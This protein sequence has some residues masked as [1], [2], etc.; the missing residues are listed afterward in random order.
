MKYAVTIPGPDRKNLDAFL[1][2]FGRHAD[3]T[4]ATYFMET[5]IDYYTTYVTMEEDE[6]IILQLKFP[7][8]FL[9]ETD[10]EYS[11]IRNNITY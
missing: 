1:D 10:P 6:S 11:Y 8:K 7:F 2:A 9:K 5:Y 3:L 4:V